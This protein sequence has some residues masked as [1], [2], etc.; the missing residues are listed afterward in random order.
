MRGPFRI[1]QYRFPQT[2]L[3]TLLPFAI[4]AF[5]PIL[6]HGASQLGIPQYTVFEPEMIGTDEGIN[7]MIVDT[8]GRILLSSGNKLVSFDGAAWKSYS[9][10]SP[11]K[12]DHPTLFAL[13]T[14]NGR[15]FC[16]SSSGVQE[17][18]FT[19]NNQFQLKLLNTGTTPA[20][21]NT[22][23]LTKTT[24]RGSSVYFYDTH[25]LLQFDTATNQVKVTE[26]KDHEYEIVQATETR[27]YSIVQNQ[28]F[29]WDDPEQ[30]SE[31]A[32][33]EPST[34]RQSIRAT[35]EWAD[36]GIM[37]APD[38]QAIGLL[39]ENEFSFWPSEI[40][41][42]ENKSI[43]DLETLSDSYL[44]ASVKTEGIFVLNTEG[45]IVQ[46]LTS[47]LDHRFGAAQN[48]LA[49]NKHTLW[50]TIGNSVARIHF[51]DL[52]TE[53]SPQVT[54][55]LTYPKI[56][57]WKG[58]AYV[59]SESKLSK[60]NFFKGGGLKSFEPFGSNI[61][62]DIDTAIPRG[63]AII[64]AGEAGIFALKEDQSFTQIS[65]K[66][67]ISLLFYSQN[68]PDQFIAAS[69]TEFLLYQK[70]D[71]AWQLHSTLGPCPPSSYFY[72]EFNSNE[73]WVEH[74][75]RNISR[76]HWGGEI[77]SVQIFGEAQGFRSGWINIFSAFGKTYFSSFENNVFGVWNPET[78]AIE[79]ATDGISQLAIE[80]SGVS[81]PFEDAQGYFWMI[82]S[83]GDAKTYTRIDS[84]NF[85]ETIQG[86]D[87]LKSANLVHTTRS[88]NG[89]DW[90]IG[91]DSIYRLSNSLPRTPSPI[92]PLLIQRIETTDTN[93][94]L[95]D[96]NHP[97]FRRALDLPYSQN[98]LRIQFLTNAT[99]SKSYPKRYYRVP[100][101]HSDWRLIPN[102]SD[103]IVF[104]GI[105]EGNYTIEARATFDDLSFG[106][107]D[108]LQL[109]IQPPFYRSTLAYGLYILG[110]IVL[111]TATLTTLRR[112]AERRNKILY[113][114][115]SERTEEVQ[116][117]NNKLNFA[118][119]ELKEMYNKAKAADDAKSA[120]LAVVSHE[121]RTPLNSIIAP[122][123]ILKLQNDDKEEIELINLIKSS[124]ERLLNLI[125]EVLEFSSND[126]TLKQGNSSDFDLREL[127]ELLVSSLQGE[128]KK[129]SLKLSLEFK[130]T[131]P[132]QLYGYPKAT[133]HILENLISNAIKYTDE[134]QVSVTVSGNTKDHH[135]QS[136]E[137][138]VN[139]SG[140]GIDP[141]AQEA[142]FDPF[143]QVDGSLNRR[144]QGIGLGLSICKQ[145]SSQIGSSISI[146]SEL[147]KGSTFTLS[148]PAN[149][150]NDS[151]QQADVH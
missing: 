17:I 89:D 109:S 146:E 144:W 149:L 123:D 43:V 7:S 44:S 9:N 138:S 54:S 136:V 66:G 148:L 4:A 99:N 135:N 113:R 103:E 145:L 96:Y 71:G 126:N 36:N 91:P 25:N 151:Y 111:Y 132:S 53:F 125:D 42:F 147:G 78:E 142:I 40:D 18:E 51:F 20:D 30:Q 14:L 70:R 11:N 112:L 88:S 127:L 69:S 82:G 62:E 134:G 120:F 131:A 48:L 133:K 32:P 119:D 104:T 55:T 10:E 107:T 76:I 130:P 116:E 83:A 61:P 49:T 80:R 98:S 38:D 77:P 29:E 35:E 81:R 19:S 97:A 27:F 5:L 31:V 106:P 139:D 65:P 46:A 41:H 101:L 128:A 50:V 72:W 129:K 64:C 22:D 105:G 74:G 1:R 122:C 85:E 79:L 13:A 28:I 110:A 75:S 90:L 143:F 67:D 3:K 34:P 15:Y 118:N 60:A 2:K 39:K 93:T 84:N 73:V 102:S 92:P 87:I 23:Y 117:A 68:H 45:N 137:I 141:S 140:I 21:S 115:V 95:F 33:N 100:G 56:F 150:S 59:E 94:T 63:D 86:T 8:H 26:P 16:S 47:R 57:E 114:L 12:Q 124:G 108:T 58:S 37:L 24:S 6:V 121:M 52:V